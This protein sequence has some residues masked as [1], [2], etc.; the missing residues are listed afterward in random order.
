MALSDYAIK[1]A[2]GKYVSKDSNVEVSE[3]N[4]I[5][6]VRTSPQQFKTY[7]AR[8][9]PGKEQYGTYSGKILVY[10]EKGELIKTVVESTYTKEKSPNEIYTEKFVAAEYGPSGELLSERKPFYKST[11]S[12]KITRGSIVNQEQFERKSDQAFARERTI[13]QQEAKAAA[14]ES[15]KLY[16]VEYQGKK[17]PTSNP[18]F[19]PQA[20]KDA[21]A[22]IQYSEKFMQK[23]QEA[24]IEQRKY[25]D[26]LPKGA[27]YKEA[28]DPYL[29]TSRKA[30][31]TKEPESRFFLESPVKGGPGLEVSSK[32][33]AKAEKAFQ[34]E[35]VKELAA[36]AKLPALPEYAQ[37]ASLNQPTTGARFKQLFGG[38]GEK[39]TIEKKYDA[40]V[41]KIT[42]TSTYKKGK[43]LVGKALSSYDS[44]IEKALPAS[45][46][47]RYVQ[48]GDRLVVANPV[49]TFL[50]KRSPKAEAFLV[51]LEKGVQII[52][53]YP[54]QPGLVRFGG[55]ILASKGDVVA[56]TVK[57]IVKTGKTP[58][59]RAELLGTATT[60]IGSARRTKATEAPA[61]LRTKQPTSP[62]FRIEFDKTPTKA[63]RTIAEIVIPEPELLKSIRTKGPIRFLTTAEYKALLETETKQRSL[64][65]QEFEKTK[66]EVQ[67]IKEA[68]LGQQTREKI[69]ARQ[70]LLRENFYKNLATKYKEIKQ[71]EPPPITQDKGR[72]IFQ[73]QNIKYL[74]E[75]RIE[76]LTK[77]F[78]RKQERYPA[79]RKAQLKTLQ[80]KLRN[81]EKQEKIEYA[82]TTESGK[83]VKALL[84]RKQL[85]R[86]AK[87]DT[88]KTVLTP[89]FG[90]YFGELTNP[91]QFEKITEKKTKPFQYL[92]E[93]KEE[94]KKSSPM[95]EIKA[96]EDQILL[97]ETIKE[98]RTIKEVEQKL[99]SQQKQLQRR[100]QVFLLDQ[101]REKVSV[102]AKIEQ[103]QR[104]KIL[105]LQKQK[106]DEKLSD[107]TLSKQDQK[108]SQRQKLGQSQTIRQL[109]QQTQ[110][111][112]TGQ[113]QRIAT[114]L[115]LEFPKPTEV[116]LK[117]LFKFPPREDLPKKRK[118]TSVFKEGKTPQYTPTLTAAFFGIKR[119]PKGYD[120]ASGLGTRPVSRRKK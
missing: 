42:D 3:E 85:R 68:E 117:T 87:A 64:K 96:G 17:Y 23:A 75:K 60:I 95:K 26:E 2:E 6:T 81:Q 54:A 35:R 45:Y 47:T 99:E 93:T 70:D 22:K 36:Q 14:T 59:G 106:Q 105:Q 41:K 110:A 65:I 39:G 90:K 15:P 82:F 76:A 30:P 13:P 31:T 61:P 40:L 118:G 94:P 104:G 32:F 108:I 84:T 66:K 12:G 55:E 44:A 103:K 86:I 107:L 62:R 88:T 72:F 100:K 111:Q 91:P 74:S 77:E 49:Q 50:A 57:E 120:I 69:Q 115:N 19:V 43:E 113:Q 58:I 63:H 97:Q 116:P 1:N 8:R 71:F 7:E 16:E 9:E 92:K 83:T 73:D 46:T 112:T 48:Q 78:Q 67:F 79:T 114:S 29:L 37:G 102:A 119:A 34:E 27:K 109:R 101:K 20:A 38:S 21:K 5:V 25:Y 51:G 80:R 11:K 52:A 28:E 98:E 4:G 18:D 24:R 89:E 10:D 53:K 56:D 33:A